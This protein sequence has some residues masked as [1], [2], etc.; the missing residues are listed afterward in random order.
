MKDLSIFHQFLLLVSMFFLTFLL[1]CQIIFFE[2]LNN[3]VVSFLSFLL[4][5]QCCV[6]FVRFALSYARFRFLIT[7]RSLLCIH[8]GC[9]C[10]TFTILLGMHS[11]ERVLCDWLC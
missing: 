2:D 6:R 4:F 9:V 8:G 5:S 1:V 11:Y 10:L 3:E 7:F